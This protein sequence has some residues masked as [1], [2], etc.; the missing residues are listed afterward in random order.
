MRAV[1][2]DLIV[3]NLRMPGM[4][5]PQFLQTLQRSPAFRRIPVLIV[6][7]FLEDAAPLRMPGLRIVGRLAKPLPLIDL[8]NAVP[9][10]PRR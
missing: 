4:A 8:L 7:A 3:L 10:A 5:A 6:S 1:I 9:A 2:P